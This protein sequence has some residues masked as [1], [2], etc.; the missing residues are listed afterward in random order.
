[1]RG[2]RAS[3]GLTPRGGWGELPTRVVGTAAPSCGQLWGGLS[4][5]RVYCPNLGGRGGRAA[6]ACG[7]GH[8]CF[9]PELGYS[10]AGGDGGNQGTR[11]IALEAGGPY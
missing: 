4:G 5:N 11:N 2:R 9:L 3:R 10:R 6:R 8:A 7:L 1:M